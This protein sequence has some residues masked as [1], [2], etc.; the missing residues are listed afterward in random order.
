[1]SRILKKPTEERSEQDIFYL[2]HNTSEL[3]F[4]HHI[5][6][7]PVN[8]ANYPHRKLC[9]AMRIEEYRKGQTVCWAGKPQ[10]EL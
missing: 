3:K 10:L 4:F 1:M 8:V 2:I 7:D 5:N 9:K 6:Q